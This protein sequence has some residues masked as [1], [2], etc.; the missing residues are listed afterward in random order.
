[1]QEAKE[2]FG[3]LCVVVLVWTH[4]SSPYSIS[5]SVSSLVGIRALILENE[6]LA[7]PG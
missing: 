6:T 3:E 2:H 7:N 1:M 5:S 4:K